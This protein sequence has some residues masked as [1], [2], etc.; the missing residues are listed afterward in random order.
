MAGGEEGEEEGMELTSDDFERKFLESMKLTEFEKRL[1]VWGWK[2]GERAKAQNIVIY[3][4]ANILPIMTIFANLT[5]L[6][7]KIIG[8]LT[9]KNGAISSFE[10]RLF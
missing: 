6:S 2:R 9:R 1:K 8:S 3:Y 4:G 5:P 10:A 7:T